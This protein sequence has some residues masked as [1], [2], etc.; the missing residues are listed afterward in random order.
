M[1]TFTIFALS[2][3]ARLDFG[4]KHLSCASH[5]PFIFTSSVK[6]T[7]QKSDSEL[8]VARCLLFYSLGISLTLTS[9]V[10]CVCASA[11]VCSLLW[12]PFLYRCRRGYVSR[13]HAHSCTAQTHNQATVIHSRCFCFHMATGGVV[14]GLWEFGV[15]TGTFAHM[16]GVPG[17]RGVG[18]RQDGRVTML[19][20]AARALS[21]VLSG[22]VRYRRAVCR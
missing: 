6:H 14:W 16:D 1:T 21:G 11:D 2:Q 13:L 22:L 8:T 12:A 4:F 20:H 3:V 7:K 15:Y 18:A 10:W 19:G 5:F 17:R 9:R